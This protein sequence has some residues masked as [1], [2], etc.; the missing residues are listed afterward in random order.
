[1][2]KYLASI[3][4]F[5]VAACSLA[6]AG[7]NK[8]TVD[9]VR[10]A[11][12]FILMNSSNNIS[13][14]NPDGT[15]L[16]SGF[17][18]NEE[19]HIVTNYHCIHNV[20]ELKLAFYDKD[21]WNVYEVVV[22]GKDPLSDLAVIHIPKRKKPLPYLEWSNEEPWGGMEVFAVGHPFGLIWSVSK[23]VVSHE[24][25]IVR[26][27]YVRLLQTDVAI[28]SGNS[29]GPLVNTAGKVVGVNAMIINP[30][31]MLPKT[32]IGL[33]LSIRNDDAKEI[34][35]V[36]K[37]GKEYV[38]PMLGVQLADL[39]PLNRDTIANMP[40][41]KEAGIVVPNTLGCFVA[42]NPNLPK[43]IEQFDVIVGI[44]GKAVNRQQNLTDVI[45]TKK[46]GDVVDL[47]IIRDKLFKNIKVTLKKLE[48]EAGT[49]YDGK[50]NIKPPNQNK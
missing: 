36:I 1:M 40:D 7:L 34:I 45:R 47:I 35:D 16:C 21:D 17:V 20:E 4:C 29:G 41:V 22:I 5:F 49:I 37:E 28:N 50:G 44:D 18:I 27:P 38:R 11:T 14:N 26:T 39:T 19:R 8:E 43:G 3:I 42:P 15:G 33:A 2:K 48:I 13:V 6:F 46:V 25:R 31:P 24:E 12:V 32:N 30:T 23:G 10:Q 9:K